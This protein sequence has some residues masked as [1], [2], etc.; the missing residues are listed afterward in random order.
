MVCPEVSDIVGED[1][2]D[3]FPEHIDNYL[4]YTL[5]YAFWSGYL[6]K[7]HVRMAFLARMTGKCAEF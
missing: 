4:A 6:V 1:T 3:V 5:S 2:K 7:N